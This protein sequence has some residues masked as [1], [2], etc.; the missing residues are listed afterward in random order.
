MMNRERTK[1]IRTAL[2]KAGYKL[3]QFS[4]RSSCSGY[5]DS[6]TVEIKDMGID[7]IE[8]KKIVS[9]YKKVYFDEFGEVLQGGN[10]YIFVK[11]KTY[12]Y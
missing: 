4:I 7:P 8:V 3:N 5:S 9:N 11:K 1:A 2:K 10:T 6:T 12:I